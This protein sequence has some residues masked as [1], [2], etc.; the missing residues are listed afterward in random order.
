MW[1]D[2]VAAVLL[3]SAFQTL[4]R[5]CVDV[6]FEPL[7]PAAL[8]ELV[9]TFEFQGLA[10]LVAGLYGCGEVTVTHTAVA[11][12]IFLLTHIEGDSFLS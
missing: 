4:F 3:A 5:V 1:H 7:L 2:Y 10:H 11:T 8:A 12:V 6:F 9:A